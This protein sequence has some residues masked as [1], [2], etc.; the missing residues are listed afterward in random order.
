MSGSGVRSVATAQTVKKSVPTT[1][2][3]LTMRKNILFRP[4]ARNYELL[5]R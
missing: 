2:R 4:F 5:I 3:N 1:E